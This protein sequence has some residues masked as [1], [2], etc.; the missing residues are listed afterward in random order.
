MHGNRAR[1][2]AAAHAP[3][4]PETIC[5]G[6]GEGCRARI[7]EIEQ[8][9]SHPQRAAGPLRMAHRA[10]SAGAV[11]IPT[12][13][14][15]ETAAPSRGPHAQAHA[16]PRPAHRPQHEHADGGL[17]YPLPEGQPGVEQALRGRQGRGRGMAEARRR[18]GRSRS[19]NSQACRAARLPL[20]PHAS[21]VRPH[22]AVAQHAARHTAPTA[23][24]VDC[25]TERSASAAPSQARAKRMKKKSAIR[26]CQGGGGSH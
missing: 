6:Q 15:T 13:H 4:A 22:K 25:S 23:R 5:R 19:H 12:E 18:A 21:R 2:R 3:A 7:R 16:S 8:P 24:T 26:I 20:C 14:A 17:E 11:T 10:A 9:R 1:A